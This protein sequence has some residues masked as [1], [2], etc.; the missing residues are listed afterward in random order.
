MKSN[1]KDYLKYWRVVKHY[2]KIRYELSQQDLEM[3]LFLKSED[4]FTREK[5]V[6]YA[7]TM[8][9][10]PKRLKKMIDAGWIEIFRP[11]KN[12]KKAIYKLSLKAKHVLNSIYRKLDGEEPIT[13]NPDL[14]PL[15]R[16]RLTYAN[17]MYSKEMDV[18]NEAILQ[19]QHRAPE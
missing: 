2:A 13:D 3:L 12:F 14:N 7:R 4:Y 19:R 18:M 1:S 17:R 6:E 11:Y 8:S 5:F 10:D 16:K 9:W 15:K